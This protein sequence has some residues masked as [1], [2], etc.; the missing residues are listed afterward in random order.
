MRD[1]AQS[2]GAGA[3]ADSGPSPEPPHL[4]AV[5]LAAALGAGARVLVLGA[6]SGRSLPPL[7]AA[8]LQIES[9]P[10]GEELFAAYPGPYDGVLSTHALL[11]GTRES[12]ALRVGLLVG[13]L[14]A[15]GRFYAT[16]GSTLD[17]RFG[18]G[19]WVPGDGWAPQEGDEAGVCHAYFDRRGV[20]ELLA[21]FTER[22]IEARDVRDLVGRWA[23][24]AGSADMPSVHWFVEAQL[25]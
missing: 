16:F 20:E 6:G 17:P 18:K 4:L 22:H 10:T 1:D 2:A 8:G 12:V 5:R 7:R 23:H 11:H 24:A 25:G 19:D 3:C 15:N 14:T 21:A 13:R 9:A